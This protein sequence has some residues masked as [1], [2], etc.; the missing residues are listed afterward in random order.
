MKKAFWI[1]GLCVAGIVLNI[2]ICYSVYY[3]FR[4]FL[5]DIYVGRDCNCCNI[6]NIEVRVG[7]NIS[8]INKNIECIYDADDDSKTVYF[9]VKLEK[10]DVEKYLITNDLKP[11]NTFRQI[12]LSHFLKLSIKPNIALENIENYYHKI[13]D[14]ENEFSIVLFDKLTGDLWI[15]LKYKDAIPDGYKFMSHSHKSF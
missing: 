11:I 14:G 8:S 5:G 13:Q 9:S 3:A 2:L 15:Y 7:I 6:D 1:T 12:D 4:S 10:L